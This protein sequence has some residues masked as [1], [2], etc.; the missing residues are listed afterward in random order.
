MRRASFD[1]RPPI[2]SFIQEQLPFRDAVGVADEGRH[3][4]FL[5]A[6]G[7]LSSFRPASCGR[8]L[9]LRVFTCLLDHTRFSHVSAPPRERGTTWSRLPSS[10][11]SN[12]A[13]V[14]AAVAVALADVP[15]AE[16]RALLRHLGEVHRHDDRRHADRA[17]HGTH[18][19]VA[20]ADGQRD[21]FVPGDWAELRSAEFGVRSA[22][23]SSR[24][25]SRGGDVGGHLAKG[26]LWRANVD[27]LPVAVQDQHNRL[28]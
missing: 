15:G 10:G 2:V 18:G 1:A 9:P 4:Q 22:V 3:R 8:R 26:V 21:P 23:A 24:N 13:G 20:V 12:A 19:V 7:A 11:C 14:L 25:S 6:R 28:V 17:A 16:L 27:R 5:R